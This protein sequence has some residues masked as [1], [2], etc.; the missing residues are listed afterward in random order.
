MIKVVPRVRVLCLS[1]SGPPIS[2]R[3]AAAWFSCLYQMADD[4]GGGG[5]ILGRSRRVPVFRRFRFQFDK[6]FDWTADG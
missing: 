5:W 4:A 6:Y 1:P 3:R 2:H